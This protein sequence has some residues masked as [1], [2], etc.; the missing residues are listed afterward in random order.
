MYF[1]PMIAVS[2]FRSSD[3]VGWV[4]DRRFLPVI[5]RGF[6]DRLWGTRH[7]W[8]SSSFVSVVDPSLTSPE[9]EVKVEVEVSSID[10][11]HHIKTRLLGMDH[12]PCV[13]A[14]RDDTVCAGKPPITRVLHMAAAAAATVAQAAACSISRLWL[15]VLTFQVSVFSLLCLVQA[16]RTDICRNYGMLSKN[17]MWISRG[18]NDDCFIQK[19]TWVLAEVRSTDNL[20]VY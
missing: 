15:A 19:K 18:K 12:C 4:T 8:S 7:I 20:L 5:S 17:Y 3:T 1:W 6:F 14:T 13:G 10:P 16:Y 2:F 11:S 9:A